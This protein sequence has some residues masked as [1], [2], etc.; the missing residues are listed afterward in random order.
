MFTANQR[1]KWWALTALLALA[2]WSAA[3]SVAAQSRPTTLWDQVQAD[4]RLRTF[5]AELRAADLHTLLQQPGPYTVLAPSDAAFQALP[6]GAWAGLS[7]TARRQTLLYHIL[8]GAH[9]HSALEAQTA[10]RTALGQPLP[11]TISNGALLI[12]GRARVT[13]ADL[14]ARN[15][16]LH[17]ID[18]VLTPP[19][20]PPIAA[21]PVPPIVW[22]SIPAAQRFGV[23]GHPGQAT[24]AR[25]AGLPFG[26]AI[27]PGLIDAAGLPADVVPWQVIRLS[28]RG[29]SIQPARLEA[30]VR[31]RP[32]A[33]WVIGNEP[34]VIWQDNVTPQ[35]YAEIYRDLYTRIKQLDPTARVA[36]GGV[37]TPTPLRRAYLD[38]VL[39]HYEQRFGG[40]L[41]ADLWT[42]HAYILREERRSW[43][44]E[45][46]PGMPWID[47][48]TL[49]EIEDHGNVEEM[50]KLL[51]EFRLWMRERGY[52]TP[53]AVTE[54][55]ILMPEDY[56]FPPEVVTAYMRRLIGFFQAADARV[57]W[58]PDG[59]RPVQYWFWF[60]LHDTSLEFSV[61]DLLDVATGRLTP[62]GRAYADLQRP[63]R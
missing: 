57:G 4:G 40:R 59:N 44:A 6:N 43:G 46:P 3:G 21:Q 52:D 27:G 2:L 36:V 9:S 50:Q 55:G 49:Y 26:S 61:S 18:A 63:T 34:D 41:P 39:R 45:I 58:A 10:A 33:I 60:S 1:A 32:G 56:G 54:F 29:A 5:A 15:G 38:L 11:L 16:V 24:Q 19:G 13:T 17:L 7:A 20:N 25:R 62:I 30:A 28:E 53:L 37:A 14:P 22:G 47:R 23:Y 12:G 31:A 35:R 42:V 48:G 8:P 51:R